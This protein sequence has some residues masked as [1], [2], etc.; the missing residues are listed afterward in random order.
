V[1]GTP[2]GIFYRAT[3]IG[4]LRFLGL[5]NVAVWLGATVFAAFVVGPAGTSEEMRE[6]L[7][8]RNFPYFSFTIGHL[9]V[10][11]GYGLQFGCG[12]VAILHLLAS[13]LYLGKSPRRLWLGLLIA[14][15]TLNFL[16]AGLVEPRLRA[17]HLL[18]FTRSEPRTVAVIRKQFNTW[19]AVSKVVNVL[20][21]GGLGVYLWRVANPPD[22]TRFVSATKFRS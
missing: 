4:F 6:V 7:G 16:G 20:M 1:L 14:L 18:Q 22:S 12:L 5:L 8:P 9:F 17:L 15:I 10:T 19:H 11:H 2:K 21:V 13:W 3:V